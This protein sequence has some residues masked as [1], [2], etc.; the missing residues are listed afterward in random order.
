MQQ[1]KKCSKQLNVRFIG[2]FSLKTMNTSDMNKIR[3]SYINDNVKLFIRFCKIHDL[4]GFIKKYCISII[5]LNAD[6]NDR[7][8]STY[9]SVLINKEYSIYTLC[10]ITNCNASYLASKK[11]ER[12]E[13]IDKLNELWNEFAKEQI[14]KDKDI[15]LKKYFN[16]HAASLSNYYYGMYDD[17][18]RQ[19]YSTVHLDRISQQ[20]KSMSSVLPDYYINN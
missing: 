14:K 18:F 10:K 19:S 13:K 15:F 17:D 11:I 20:I 9:V 5:H 1:I 8:V 6:L 12:D 7:P 16:K 2:K 4:Y 3:M